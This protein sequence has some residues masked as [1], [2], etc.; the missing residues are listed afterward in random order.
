[1]AGAA[2][3]ASARAAAAI[4]AT[5]S[6]PTSPLRRAE[7]TESPDSAMTLTE[8]PRWTPFVVVEFSA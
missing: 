1:M 5:P 4:S 8:R 3:R 2:C 6:A 7:P